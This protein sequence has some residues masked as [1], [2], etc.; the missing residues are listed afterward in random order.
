LLGIE[1]PMTKSTHR[2]RVALNLPESVPSLLGVVDVVLKG[3]TGNPF[4]PSPQPS[5]AS[6]AAVLGELRDAEV[7]ALS[8]TRGTVE[9]RDEKLAALRSLLGRL[10]AYVQGVADDDPEHAGSII[11]SAGMSLWRAGAGA[12][13]PF[14]VKAAEVDGSVELAVR[15]AAK[16]ATYLW[17]WSA[18]DGKTWNRA[19]ATRQ[20]KTTVTGLPSG[21]MCLFRF[22]SVVRSGESDWSEPLAF[23]VP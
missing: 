21:V 6:V 7:A 10:K 20:T 2:L 5:L 23:R 16:D 4:F 18:D 13:A 14:T 15:A 19:P 1:A 11:E 17:Q 12:K 9:L 22:R 8:R 3:M